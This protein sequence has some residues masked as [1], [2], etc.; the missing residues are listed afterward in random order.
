MLIVSVKFPKGSRNK[1]VFIWLE[2]E[3]AYVCEVLESIFIAIPR[4]LR[5]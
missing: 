1:Q 4:G 2:A 3:H 5:S